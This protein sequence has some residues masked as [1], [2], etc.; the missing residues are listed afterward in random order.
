MRLVKALV[1][2]CVSLTMFSMSAEA[3]DE[4]GEVFDEVEEEEAVP[5]TAVPA[6]QSGAE[7]P[8]TPR[9]S[10]RLKIKIADWPVNKILEVLYDNGLS[11]PAGLDHEALFQFLVEADRAAQA[12]SQAQV[13]DTPKTKTRGGKRSAKANNTGP[14]KKKKPA[15]GKLFNVGESGPSGEKP[16]KVPA[17]PGGIPAS[18]ADPTVLLALTDIKNSLSGMN[19]R[20]TSLEAGNGAGP[21][22]GVA[23]FPGQPP[24]D[25]NNQPRKNLGTAVPAPASGSAFLSPAAA[26]PDTLRSQILSGK[27]LLLFSLAS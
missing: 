3:S 7:V 14:I 18:T 16:G 23:G 20:I 4:E 6:A 9:R 21:S 17:Q 11:A 27:V 26:I 13:S 25:A 2:V 22:T 24:S 1:L 10:P 8:P 15:E 19:Q 5:D 12:D